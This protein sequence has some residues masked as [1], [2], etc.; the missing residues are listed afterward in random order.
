MSDLL[1]KNAIVYTND[2]YF[3]GWVSIKNGIIASMGGGDAP[4]LDVETIDALGQRLLPGFIDTHVHGAVGH[5]TMD[6][7]LDGLQ[8]MAQFFASR[9]VTAFT[10]TT[11]TSSHEQI[12]AALESVKPLVGG[13]FEWGRYC[14]C[15]SRRTLPQCRKMWRSEPRLC[16]IM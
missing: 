13:G 4:N 2:D 8:K 7:D 14:R 6:A 5:D 3:S 16:A 10:P 11:L 9:G 1:I 12:L 15:A